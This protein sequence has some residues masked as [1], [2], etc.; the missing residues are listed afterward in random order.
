MNIKKVEYYIKVKKN[1]KIDI[2]FY[3][4]WIHIIF[5]YFYL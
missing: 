1:V 3:V 5:T 4:V 2:I